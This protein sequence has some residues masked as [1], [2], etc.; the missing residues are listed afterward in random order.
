MPEAEL[1]RLAQRVGERV[2]V[3]PGERLELPPRRP[4]RADEV[5]VV[6]VREAVR[7]SPRLGDDGALL[8]RE[9]RL[10]RTHHG[11]QRLDRLPALRICERVAAT[12][13]D[14]ELDPLGTRQPPEEGSRLSG[15]GSELEMGLAAQR[16]RPATEEGAAQI[17]AAAAAPR[18]DATGR[19]FQR[20][21]SPVDD[22]GRREHAQRVLVTRDMELVARA[23]KT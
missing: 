5:R 4:A 14:L 11:Q 18:H 7:P 23:V 13:G 15:C 10:L 17:G 16:D 19:P 22:A 12:L 6:G 1:R 20:R 8:Q 3:E 2:Q 9:H 21:M